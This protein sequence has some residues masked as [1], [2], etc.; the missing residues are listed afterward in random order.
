ML[1]KY[2]LKFKNDPIASVKNP[3]YLDASKVLIIVP[4][5]NRIVGLERDFIEEAKDRYGIVCDWDWNMCL[6]VAAEQ[7][8]IQEGC[9]RVKEEKDKEEKKNN[10]IWNCHWKKNEIQ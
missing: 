10:E 9:K 5:T 1:C 7:T 4:S 3:T 2:C 6:Q 8:E